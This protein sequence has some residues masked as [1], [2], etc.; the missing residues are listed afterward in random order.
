MATYSMRRNFITSLTL[1]D[2]SGV[3]EHEQKAGVLWSA[4]RDGLG[5]LEFTGL[6]FDLSELI[7]LVD[8]PDLDG[9]FSMVEISTVLKNIPLDHAPGPHG[10]NGAFFKRCWTI[11]KDGILRLCKD[12]ADGHLNLESINGS[13]ITLIPKK[14]NRGL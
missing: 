12:F 4:F 9:P 1:E 11:I 7:P 10:F 13:L 2:G 6:L 5:V 3:F 14:D 8:W